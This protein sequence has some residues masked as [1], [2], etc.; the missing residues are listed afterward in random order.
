MSIV[1]GHTRFAQLTDLVER[2]LAPD[3]C[4][5]V[6]RHLASCSRCSRDVAWLE[7]T[8]SLMRS[9][10]AEDAPEFVVQ[11]AVR[12]FRRPAEPV[13]LRTRIQAMLQFDSVQH[14]L[15]PAFNVRNVLPQFRQ[16]FFSA[17]EHDLDLRVVPSGTEWIVS[18]QLLGA[19]EMGAVTL[20]GATATV[21]AQLNDTCEFLLPPVP[22]GLYG[23]VLRLQEVDV[24]VPQFHVGI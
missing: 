24:T 8:I 4:A 20:E 17:G 7:R 21:Q 3:E 22:A 19:H 11:R 5:A 18:G 2:R 14:S 15:R 10:V 6:V 13:T 1:Y 9:D 16:L 12:L 23:M